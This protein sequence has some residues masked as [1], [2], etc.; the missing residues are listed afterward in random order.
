MCFHALKYHNVLLS[1]NEAVDRD[2]C[3]QFIIFFLC[4]IEDHFIS[5]T[6][7]AWEETPIDAKCM[8]INADDLG[9]LLLPASL[10]I[11]L[12]VIFI[13]AVDPWQSFKALV[14]S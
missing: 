12:L 2:I 9:I 3:P 4:F 10:G 11:L 14:I 1:L 13:F 7:H 5:L 6:Q 8:Q